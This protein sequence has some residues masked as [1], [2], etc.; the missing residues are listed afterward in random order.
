MAEPQRLANALSELIALRGLANSRGRTEMQDAWAEVARE[1]GHHTRA[2][3][4]KRGVLHV[5]VSN[6]PL[7]SELDSYHKANLLNAIREQF[8]STRVRD[9]KFVLKGDLND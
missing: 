2:L 7:R 6:A 4:L 5:G 9:L 3:E 1:W 8:P